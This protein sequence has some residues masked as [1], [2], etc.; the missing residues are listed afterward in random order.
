MLSKW[1]SSLWSKFLIIASILGFN[2]FVASLTFTSTV[3]LFLI[4]TIFCLE[5]F[6]CLFMSSH[7]FNNNIR[8]NSYHYSPHE[9]INSILGRGIR[10]DD[11][12]GNIC[13]VC[14]VVNRNFSLVR[15]GIILLC[16]YFHELV[17]NGV[18]GAWF[19]GYNYQE[20]FVGGSCPVFIDV[21]IRFL[22]I[23]LV[24]CCIKISSIVEVNV[25][26]LVVVHL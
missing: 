17:T 6:M 2:V 7:Y 5:F 26:I 20:D 24:I 25:H 9:S 10:N 14:W 18:S 3:A 11:C 15:G 4:R 22:V 19:V 21:R 12:L 13:W 23:D 1:I 16:Y 8:N